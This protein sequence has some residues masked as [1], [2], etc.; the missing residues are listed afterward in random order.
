LAELV[1]AGVS[2][3]TIEK[4][5][6]ALARFVPAAQRQ[7]AQ[8][9]IL[10]EGREL[11]LRRGEG[12]VDVAGQRR[13]DFDAQAEGEPSAAKTAAP[14]EAEP[15]AAS[16]QEP[17]IFRLPRPAVLPPATDQTP[18]EDLLAAA[19][20]L[21]DEGRLAEAA[22][23]YR[24]L[25]GLVGPTAELCF[26]LAELLYRMGDLSAARERYYM[27][28]ELD[29]DYVEA[30]ANLGCVLAESG[31]L[32]LAAAAFEGALARHPDFPDAHYH[33]ARTLEELH[34]RDEARSHWQSFLALSPDSPWADEARRRLE[35]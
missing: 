33:L 17:R 31:E 3:A 19:I 18:P 4:Q 16:P 10:V 35:V 6:A 9:S 28:V 11:L 25:I 21:D 20:D 15:A 32:E 30:R 1:T 2:P 24:A 8:L 13:L 23:T 7:L 34:R 26:Q 29:E 14:A 12:L 27:A 22:A 5:L